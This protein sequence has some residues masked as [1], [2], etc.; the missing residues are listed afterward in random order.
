[1]GSDARREILFYYMT[2]EHCLYYR[3]L[4]SKT[5]VNIHYFYRNKSIVL[6]FKCILLH[7]SL[8]LTID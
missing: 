6:S 3:P 7:S 8:K 2:I 1:M 4:Y 5:D